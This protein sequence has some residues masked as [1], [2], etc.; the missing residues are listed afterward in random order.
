MKDS[1]LKPKKILVVCQ[2]F[3]P[4][5]F[6]ISDICEGL[7]ENGYEVDV[8]CGIPNYPAGKF[9]AGY[10]FLKKRRQTHKGINIIRVSEIPRGNNSNPRIFINYVSFPLF[11]LFYLPMLARNNYDRVLVYGLSPVFMAFPAILLAKIKKIKLYIYVMDFWPHS[12]FSIMNFENKFIRSAITKMSYWHYRQADGL[13]AVYKGIQTRLV[14]IVG[15]DEEKT[16]YIPQAPEK[17]YE[18]DVPNKALSK[19][20]NGKFNIVFAGNIN[21]AQS[22]E[23]VLGAVKKLHDA[24]YR[25]FTFIILGEG[26]SKRW[27]VEEVGRLGLTD[28]FVFEGLFPVEEVPKYHTIADALIVA[29][30]RDPLFEYA[31]PAKI[32]SYLASGRPIIGAMDGEGQR[33]V[34][35]SGS[36]ICVDSGDIDGL[37]EAI[38]KIMGLSD[39]ERIK[40]G[41]R[42]RKY[43][44][45]YYERNKNLSRLI[46]FVFNDKRVP[47][48]EY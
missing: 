11:A 34:N 19:R 17:L 18:Q 9:F 5:T 42:G 24:E 41:K 23:T 36:G 32:Q 28:Y 20:F 7:V 15:V 2:H 25:D 1:A 6:R 48:T 26:M 10:G 3:W 31:T 46:D 43:H 47:D 13:L 33:I 37:Y 8:L 45:K 44:F 29:L 35:Q 12:L 38:K 40:M 21:P 4:E 22:F 30:S 39:A 14:D 16:I 27:L